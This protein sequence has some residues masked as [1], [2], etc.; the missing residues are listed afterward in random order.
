MGPKFWLVRIVQLF[1]F[2]KEAGI[3]LGN[4]T[5]VEPERKNKTDEQDRKTYLKKDRKT[6]VEPESKK[7]T[8]EKDLKT[9]RNTYLKKD[10]EHLYR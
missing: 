2:E 1:T 5:S 3:V 8:D 7:K 6:S 4:E 9:D 10:K